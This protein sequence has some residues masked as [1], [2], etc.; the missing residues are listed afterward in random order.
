MSTNRT[1][2]TLD[3]LLA[4]GF[5]LLVLAFFMIPRPGQYPGYLTSQIEPQVANGGGR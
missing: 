2:R 4:V 5:C 3:L 1:I